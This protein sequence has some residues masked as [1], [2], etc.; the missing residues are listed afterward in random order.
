MF[1]S[2]FLVVGILGVDFTS[3]SELQFVRLF[4]EVMND[5]TYHLEEDIFFLNTAF[6]FLIHSKCNQYELDCQ[7]S[8]LLH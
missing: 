1:T 3:L 7:Y 8:H 2:F 6:A 4:L 5:P